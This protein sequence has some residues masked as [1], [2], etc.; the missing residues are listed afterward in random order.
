[1]PYCQHDSHNVFAIRAVRQ[2]EDCV[3]SVYNRGP[4][5]N[6][7]SLSCFCLV[8]TNSGDEDSSLMI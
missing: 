8:L 2:G 7:I 4:V 6:F 5:T 1:M 3:R